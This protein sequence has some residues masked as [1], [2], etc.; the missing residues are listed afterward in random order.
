MFIEDARLTLLEE[1]ANG[2]PS[3][4]TKEE[5][6]GLEKTLKEHEAW[7]VE[8]VEKQKSVKMNED[9]V[10]LTSEMKARAKTLENH[11]QKL[12]RKKA[13]KPKKTT[14]TATSSSSAE[15]SETV[16]PKAE[17]DKAEAQSTTPGS[18][19]AS[20]TGSASDSASSVPTPSTDDNTIHDEL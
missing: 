14:T 7:L 3:K 4:Y 16:S 10:I 17:E 5:L 12:V 9:P 8:W 20:G 19:D 1:E 11:L 18:S 2:L 6:D 13:P 15:P